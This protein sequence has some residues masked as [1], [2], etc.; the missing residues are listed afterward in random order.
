MNSSWPKCFCVSRYFHAG[1]RTGHRQ[2]HNRTRGLGTDAGTRTGHWLDHGRT[3]G[4]GTDAGTGAG[5]WLD[6]S[7]TRGLGTDAGTRTG[8]RLDHERT[9]G[10]G[11]DAGTRTGHWL[12]HS[13]TGGANGPAKPQKRDVNPICCRFARPASAQSGRAGGG[14]AA[15]TA[16]SS[17]LL[18][19]A[20]CPARPPR[21]VRPVPKS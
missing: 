4:L 2:D 10:L 8:H 11:T 20:C 3:R 12:D 16:G 17:A 6:H 1:T 15:P 9:G 19:S 13:R 7:R 14:R 18:R 5:H 21:G